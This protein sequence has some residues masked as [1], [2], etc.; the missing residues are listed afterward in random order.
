M[1]KWLY[2]EYTTQID[3]IENPDLY[4]EVTYRVD[5]YAAKEPWNEKPD[6]VDYNVALWLRLYKSKCD[7]VEC[8]IQE[9]HLK[10]EYGDLIENYLEKI[11]HL[12]PFKEDEPDYGD[13]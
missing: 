8:A 3:L 7:E 9:K 6:K 13:E 2:G 11:W 1:G 12:I 5:T 10:A 4:L